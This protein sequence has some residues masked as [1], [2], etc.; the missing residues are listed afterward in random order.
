MLEL[1]VDYVK[2]APA[3]GQAWQLSGGEASSGRRACGAGAGA[4][5]SSITRL[6]AVAVEHFNG[7]APPVT[8]RTPG[9]RG[10]TVSWRD[11]VQF[12]ARSPFVDEAGW[13]WISMGLAMWHRERVACAILMENK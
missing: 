12:R 6:R 1:A 8:P 9:A 4:G 7:Q 5:R 3:I 11:W 2:V 13:G 10:V